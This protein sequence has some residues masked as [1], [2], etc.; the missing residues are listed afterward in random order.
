[1]IAMLTR[2]DEAEHVAP[3]LLVGVANPRT[4]S[5]LM[6]LGGAVARHAG[7]NVVATHV[8]TVPP[9]APLSSA[10]DAP[11]TTAARHLLRETVDAA[12]AQ[13]AHARGVV[14]IAREVDGG[15]VSAATS[16]HA[17]LVL[18]GLSEPGHDAAE[19]KFDRL[20]DRVAKTC[21]AP[22]VVAKFRV[23]SAREVLVL[24][25]DETDLATVGTLAQALVTG[26]GATARFLHVVEGDADSEE[27]RRRLAQRLT[28]H[29][30]Q[31]LGE[32]EIASGADLIETALTRANEH[33][34]TVASSTAH[35]SLS[36]S[37]FGTW[38]ERLAT[39]AERNVLVVHPCRTGR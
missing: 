34:F 1:M 29:G 7:Y 36:E 13:G 10:R 6:D 17:A 28:G 25:D 31:D 20:M 21:P 8:V 39:D 4:A 19:R 15:L 9:Q 24:I 32:L 33:D 26:R 3:T 14:E 16:Q 38:A 12:A 35:P 5:R 37:I 27:C 11:R 23:E 22:L 18:V 2:P 30:L